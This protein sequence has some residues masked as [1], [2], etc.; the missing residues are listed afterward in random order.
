MTFTIFCEENGE[1]TARLLIV[2]ALLARVK[3]VYQCH[4]SLNRC[5]FR[6]AQHPLDREHNK[7]L[8]DNFLNFDSRT[9]VCVLSTNEL[10]VPP[11]AYGPYRGNRWIEE[12]RGSSQTKKIPHTPKDLYLFYL[13]ASN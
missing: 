13:S 4:P 9:A 1:V 3:G 2:L 8:I 6:A 5:L 10:C 7:S 12:W 11:R